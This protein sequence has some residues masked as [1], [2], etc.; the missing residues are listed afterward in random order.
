MTTVWLEDMDINGRIINA[1]YVMTA[2]GYAFLGFIVLL[3][4]CMDAWIISS[5]VTSDIP[6]GRKVLWSAVVVFL[7]LVGW[8]LWGRFGPR[9]MI[10][11]PS[12]AGQDAESAVH[13][14]QLQR[15][16]PPPRPRQEQAS[17]RELP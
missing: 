8:A 13:E 5:I 15:R 16:N 10:Y 2:T 6:R 9:G 3:V 14:S 12:T 17:Y 7:P 1:G 11:P 4:V